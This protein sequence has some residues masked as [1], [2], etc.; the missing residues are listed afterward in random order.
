MNIIY[1]LSKVKRYRRPV[2]VLGVFDGMHLGH[3]RI[4]KEVV[5]LARRI[6]GTSIVLTFFPHPQ[7]KESIYSLSHRLKLIA[8]VRID[9]CIVIRF[10]KNFAQVS[11]EGFVK[12]ILSNKLKAYYIC[13]GKNFR[14][15][16]AAQGNYKTLQ[17]LSRR[18]NFK[19]KVFAVIKLKRQPVS[20][21]L[22]RRLILAG[23]LDSARRLL[24]EPVSILGTVIKGNF[25]ARRLGFP[26]ANIDP[27][28]EVLAPPGVYAV[29]IIFNKR[30]FNG[31]CYIGG[32]PTFKKSHQVTPST[33]LGAGRSPSH[34]KHIE[35]HIF[36]F[37]KNIYG[38]DLQIQ[39]VKK[40]RAEQKFSSPQALA[41]QIKKDILSHPKAISL[42]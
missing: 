5:T 33:T 35:V 17:R 7:K 11:A 30:K 38:K 28:H 4:L 14:F 15:G 20:S 40:I 24:G 21:S 22:I 39:F 12:N 10:N 9:V 3:R 25:L 41:R 36:N 2:V 8:A 13:V 32:R 31:I 27:H 42:P 26:T 6:K 18:Y 1:G 34:Q 37:K 29:K 16:K 23:K 19:V